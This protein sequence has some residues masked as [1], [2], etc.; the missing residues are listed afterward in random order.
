MAE[1]PSES[2]STLLHSHCSKVL[3]KT[4]FECHH[5]VGN[6]FWK[7]TITVYAHIFQSD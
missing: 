3:V 7:I 1:I 4:L 6:S 5:C 2:S